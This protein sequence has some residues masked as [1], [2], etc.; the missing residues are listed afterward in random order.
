MCY[1]YTPLPTNERR[2]TAN[3]VLVH[4][5][6]VLANHRGSHLSWNERLHRLRADTLS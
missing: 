5:A 3:H 6:Q 1:Q 2:L 4:R